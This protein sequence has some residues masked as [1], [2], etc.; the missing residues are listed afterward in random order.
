MTGRGHGLE[1]DVKTYLG[2]GCYKELIN[3]SKAGVF[4]KV[5]CE[6]FAYK[7]DLE[8]GGSV[9]SFIK[10]EGCDWRAVRYMLTEWYQKHPETLSVRKVVEILRD[11]NLDLKALA[12]KIEKQIKPQPQDRNDRAFARTALRQSQRNLKETRKVE[13]KNKKM[14]SE[15]EK[16]Q[17]EVKKRENKLAVERSE[18][19][20]EEQRFAREKIEAAKKLAEEEKELAMRKEKVAQKHAEEEKILQMKEAKVQEEA[21]KI[22]K[23]KKMVAEKEK[24]LEQIANQMKSLALTDITDSEVKCAFVLLFLLLAP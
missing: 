5:H 7:I 6:D 22:A 16:E 8:I 23:D 20:E 15:I 12:H 1:P 4:E 17:K 2:E 10:K 19:D 9:T 21:V 24:N 3:A 14:K 13:A 11:P 18:L